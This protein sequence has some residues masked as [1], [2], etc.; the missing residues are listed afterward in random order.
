[1]E[2]RAMKKQIFCILLLSSLGVT[3][4]TIPTVSNIQ[5]TPRAM[6]SILNSQNP[7][8]G[9]DL[10][11]GSKG[12]R[13][14]IE[15]VIEIPGNLVNQWL[16][17]ESIRTASFQTLAHIAQGTYV[18]SL[19]DLRAS[20]GE[21]E[22]HLEILKEEIL[23]EGIR[24]SYQVPEA[25]NGSNQI[26][27][28]SS[29]QSGLYLSHFLPSLEGGKTY[30]LSEPTNLKST[31]R[32]LLLRKTAKQKGKK[33]AELSSAEIQSIDNLPNQ[34]SLEKKIEAEIMKKGNNSAKAKDIAEVDSLIT[35][36]LNTNN[37]STN[38]NAN[39]NTNANTNGSTNANTNGSTNANTNGNTNANTNG[40]TNANTNG[41]TNTNANTNA[42]TNGN[43]NGNENAAQG[44]DKDK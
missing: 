24:I 35:E 13:N 44:K 12:D 31:V 16:S 8:P 25:P 27:E 32:A 6:S 34:V 18:H 21:S 1:M 26:L 4:C 28:I 37:A 22:V 42:N 14:I 15:G 40:N 11:P 17:S 3:A 41:N 29:V 5:S 38:G 36:A 39:G 7:L 43:G 20:L 33:L 19:S 23:P 2:A 30:R 10:R 9:L